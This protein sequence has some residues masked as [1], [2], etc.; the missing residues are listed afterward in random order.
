M[1]RA[2]AAF[3]IRAESPVTLDALVLADLWNH[4]VTADMPTSA[5]LIAWAMDA[6]APRSVG[7]WLAWQDGQPVGFATA[8]HVGD[9]S[10]GWVDALAVPARSNR[11]AMRTA[12]LTDAAAWLQATGCAVLQ[13]GGGPRSLM[14][15][16]LDG[17]QRVDF[18]V[19]RGFV[20]AG[21]VD[22][23]AVDLA[24]YAPPT[25]A[26]PFA[27]VVRP[28][29]PRDRDDVDAL[30]AEPSALVSEAMGAEVDTAA[31]LLVKD[32]LRS[33]RFADLMLLWSA[34]GLEAL[35]ILIFA[36]SATPIELAYPYSLPRPWALLG[37]AL[38][39]T[40]T[41]PGASGM[42]LDASLRRLHSNGVN[43]CV[44]LGVSRRALYAEYGFKP[45]RTWKV[46]V[47]RL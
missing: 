13:V 18:F 22:D 47:K 1:S 43:S 42:L 27:G 32:T 45:L 33:G 6:H 26:S 24:R 9:C 28:P 34:R 41:A 29:R 5:H 44:A 7:V 21:S 35:S 39:R 30:L 19:S 25:N 16:A 11:A 10:V 38:A 31:L 15:G 4:A 14:R 2:H 46:F 23:M 17:G 36:D 20:D 12:L 37:P 8:S 3:Q 40:D